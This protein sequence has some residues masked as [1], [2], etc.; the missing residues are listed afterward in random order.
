MAIF[1][2]KWKYFAPVTQCRGWT[3]RFELAI[4]LVKAPTFFA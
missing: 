2:L 4:T 3:T 1:E